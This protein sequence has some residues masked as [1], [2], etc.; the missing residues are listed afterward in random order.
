MKPRPQRELV[1]APNRDDGR[2]YARINRLDS[3]LI[4]WAVKQLR[5]G[6]TL[7]PYRIHF[8]PP[9]DPAV[10]ERLRKLASK[11]SHTLEQLYAFPVL[12]VAERFGGTLP[13]PS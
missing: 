3:P 12:A 13:E 2:R 4:L 8:V 7:D 11:T 5:G 9:L 10:V 1:I 6:M